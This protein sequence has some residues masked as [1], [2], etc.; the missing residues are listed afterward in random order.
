[1]DNEARGSGLR[2]REHFFDEYGSSS[3][4]RDEAHRSTEDQFRDADKPEDPTLKPPFDEHHSY[5][6]RADRKCP[7]QGFLRVG[8]FGR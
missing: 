4:D 8:H 7:V 2:G 3:S 6:P 1:M 5:P